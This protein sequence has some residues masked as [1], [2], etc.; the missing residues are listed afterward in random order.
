MLN[1]IEY[2]EKAYAYLPEREK[3]L[4]REQIPFAKKMTHKLLNL[5][6]YER[7]QEKR[8]T[9]LPLPERLAKFRS[10]VLSFVQESAH[11]WLEILEQSEEK[12][13]SVS[14]DPVPHHHFEVI[15][16]K[17]K[18]KAASPS[19]SK[20]LKARPGKRKMSLS[21]EE[22]QAKEAYRRAP[23]RPH[24]HRAARAKS[25]SVAKH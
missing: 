14:L 3:Q 16:N 15:P 24:I 12:S 5:I 17:M 9:A 13:A 4:L 18:K 2:F 22:I 11:A 10:Q 21:K 1:S 20:K 7:A 23:A 6:Q 25:A 8:G 19:R